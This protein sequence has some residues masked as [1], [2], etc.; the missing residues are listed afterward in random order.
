[1]PAAPRA[2]SSG[3]TEYLHFPAFKGHI[4]R[5]LEG[6]W[7]ENNRLSVGGGTE[8]ILIFLSDIFWGYLMKNHKYSQRN[9]ILTDPGMEKPRF[10][11]F[12]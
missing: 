6:Q 12:E 1:M 10:I 2:G 9:E 4:C 3:N 5:A 7:M 11:Y 8:G